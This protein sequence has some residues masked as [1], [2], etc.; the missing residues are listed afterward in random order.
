MGI[1]VNVT[2]GVYAI[3]YVILSVR[4]L[5]GL[6]TGHIALALLGD[7]LIDVTLLGLEVVTYVIGIIR[8]ASVHENR[9]ALPFTGRILNSVGIDQAAVHL[10]LYHGCGELDILVVDMSVT[11]E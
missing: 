5:L 8:S 10:H 7:D 2:G 1:I 11:V 6:V 4:T 9:T 3:G